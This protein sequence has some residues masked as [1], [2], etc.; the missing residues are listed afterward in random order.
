[1]Q[2]RCNLSTS[3]EGPRT[4]VWS[5]PGALLADPLDRRLVDNSTHE[6]A[7]RIVAHA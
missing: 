5:E 1:M 3:V 2:V 7:L 4:V 6:V